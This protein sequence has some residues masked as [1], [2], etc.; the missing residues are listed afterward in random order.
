MTDTGAVALLGASD[1]RTWILAFCDATDETKVSF[2]WREVSHYLSDLASGTALKQ[3]VVANP[4][5]NYFTGR[6]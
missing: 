6:E 1:Y 2:F 5:L 3:A 4:W